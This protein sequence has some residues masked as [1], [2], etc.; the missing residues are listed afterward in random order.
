MKLRKWVKVSLL[1]IAEIITVAFVMNVNT[2]ITF[3]MKLLCT[4]GLLV[5]ENLLMFMEG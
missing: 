5:I 4:C 2:E 1:I 3:A